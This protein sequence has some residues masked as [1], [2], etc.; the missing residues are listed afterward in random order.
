M[1]RFKG[2]GSGFRLRLRLR[3]SDGFNVL[4]LALR[5]PPGTGNETRNIQERGRRFLTLLKGTV[6]GWLKGFLQF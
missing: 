5:C 4:G 3:S 2:L 1:F 6:G